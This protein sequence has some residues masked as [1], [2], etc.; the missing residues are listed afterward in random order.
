MM[1]LAAKQ[2]RLLFAVSRLMQTEADV[3]PPAPA[4]RAWQ[5]L[6]FGG[7]AAFAF[8]RLGRV[9][10]LQFLVA[11]LLAGAVCWFLAVTWFPTAR[12]AIRQLPETGSIESG[13]LLIPLE[14]PALLG[15]TRFLAFVLDPDAGGSPIT[16][17]ADLRLE[18]HRTNIALCSAVGC[19]HRAYPADRVLPFNR[20]DL[21][22]AWGAW[23]PMFFLFA[24]IGM[25]VSLLA[26]W[27]TLAC[28]YF[29]VPWLIAY[30][31]DRQL[32]AAG[33]WKLAAAA[34]LPGAL[35]LTVGL[36]LYGLGLLSL[37]QLTLLWLVHVPLGWVYLACAPRRLPRV[38][39]APPRRRNPF[40]R[41]RREEP[42]PTKPKSPFAAP[43][44]H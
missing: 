13:Q 9:L 32:N 16:T 1:E 15:Q 37:V 25:V 43:E 42:A 29:P 4:P 2:L 8:A 38:A 10:L 14:S 41:K 6:T 28:L 36:V 5:P 30:F 33:A 20:A 21:E 39:D 7:V 27:F 22:A 12:Q 44:P 17:S 35:L 26:L 40:R 18:F 34:L 19:L 11:S 23:Q 24:S 3:S 31:N